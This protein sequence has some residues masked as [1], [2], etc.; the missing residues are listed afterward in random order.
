MVFRQTIA[1]FA[2]FCVLAGVTFLICSDATADKPPAGGIEP[3]PGSSLASHAELDALLQMLDARRAIAGGGGFQW[4]FTFERFTVPLPSVQDYDLALERRAANPLDGAQKDAKTTFTGN[5]TWQSSTNYFLFSSSHVQRWIGGLADYI[6]TRE[7]I[8]FNGNAFFEVQTTKRGAELPLED[9]TQARSPYVDPSPVGTIST[10]MPRGGRVEQLAIA[11][12]YLFRPGY[13]ALPSG[14]KWG[15]SVETAEF[16]RALARGGRE[17]TVRKDGELVHVSFL[18]PDENGHPEGKG[19]MTLTFNTDQ[20]AA[21]EQITYVSN[22]LG[23]RKSRNA[24]FLIRN[25]EISPGVW[26]PQE[27]IWGDWMNPLVTRVRISE[28]EPI[29]FLQPEDFQVEFPLGTYVTDERNRATSVATNGMV[30]ES[31]VLAEYAAVYLKDSSWFGERRLS[32]KSMVLGSFL[33]GS[34][35]LPII[36][37]MRLYRKRA[38]SRSN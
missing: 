34:A 5:V 12:G 3:R 31:R 10:E 35:L 19:T 16:L 23:G 29:E 15:Q 17:L 32:W 9:L 37:W 21:V 20:L 25:A 36:G 1:Q 4:K 22:G 24:D 38:Q 2:S 33:L 7:Q 26:F 11:S 18:V 30:D 14:H 6:G 27:I 8:G 28:V 13:M